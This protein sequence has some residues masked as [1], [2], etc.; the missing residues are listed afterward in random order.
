[1][2]TVRKC[3]D[4]HVKLACQ[5]KSR[6]LFLSTGEIPPWVRGSL[7]RVGPGKYEW[8][9]TKYNH[10]FEGEGLLHKFEIK[11]D[12]KVQYSSRFVRSKSYV[13]SERRGCIALDSFC[14][15]APPDPCQNIFG[16]FFSYFFP[17]RE[18]ADRSNVSVVRIKGQPYASADVT[19]MCLIDPENLD[20]VERVNVQA[21]LSGIKIYT[22]ILSVSELHKKEFRTIHL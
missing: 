9:D 8:G 16:K 4:L 17:P 15:I 20:T 11:N 1:M 5:A 19:V 6:I 21:Q 12:V 3:H 7:L 14:T 22:Y 13:E 18:R 10:W 2:F